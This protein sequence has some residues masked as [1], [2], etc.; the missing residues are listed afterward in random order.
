[1]SL[2]IENKLLQNQTLSDNDIIFEEYKSIKKTFQDNVCDLEIFLLLAAFRNEDGQWVLDPFMEYKNG[3]VG[4]NHGITGLK[5]F[6]HTILDCRQML[7]L[8]YKV[9]IFFLLCVFNKRLTI[10]SVL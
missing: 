1:M 6:G 10:S 5:N 4:N 9:N 3:I 2:H 7:A 8:Y